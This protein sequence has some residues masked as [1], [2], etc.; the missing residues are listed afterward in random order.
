ML[1]LVVAALAARILVPV[2]WMPVAAP[3]TIVMKLCDGTSDI[4]RPIG[5]LAKTNKLPVGD[6]HHVDHSCPFA[7]VTLPFVPV[8]WPTVHGHLI[9]KGILSRA[10]VIDSIITV[11]PALLPPAT[12]PPTFPA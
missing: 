9:G 8:T 10:V 6:G 3:G 1:L 4:D 11:S 12:G 2:G 7:A 5:D